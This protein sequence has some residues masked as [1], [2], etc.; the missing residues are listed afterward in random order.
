[1]IALKRFITAS[2]GSPPALESGGG[3]MRSQGTYEARAGEWREK[4][5][6]AFRPERRASRKLGEVVDGETIA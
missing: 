1:M 5:Q 2:K 6:K 4:Q 3:C